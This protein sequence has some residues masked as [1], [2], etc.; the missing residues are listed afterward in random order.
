[1]DPN[2]DFEE[3]FELLNRNDV[4]YL[5]VGGYAYAIYANP[6]YTKDV[7]IFYD[8][9]PDNADRLLKTIHEFGFGSLDIKKEDFL[10]EGQVIQ[11][12]MPPYRI[13]LLNKIEG[14][15][16][17]DAWPNRQTS[18]Y[19]KQTINVIGKQDLIRNKIATGRDQDKLDVRNLKKGL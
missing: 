13:D 4:R 15:T 12:G 16:F 19:G 14:V 10:K 6:R 7:D 2:K 18:R 11:L 9:E 17:T 3:L 1:M 5:L 8:R